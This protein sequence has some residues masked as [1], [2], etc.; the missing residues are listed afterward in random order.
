MLSKAKTLSGY[1][2]NSHDGKIGKVKEFFFDDRH[3]ENWT[4]RYLI[5]DTLNWWT[6]KKVLIATQ[7][8][9]RVSWSESKVFINLSR[10]ESGC[11]DFVLSP[12][13]IAGKIV[14]ISHTQ[15]PATG[16]DP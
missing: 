15:E 14:R 6:G 9:E 5:V 7:W 16:S 4:I 1:K 13:D 12:E 8:I 3:D 2:L 10:I 11:I